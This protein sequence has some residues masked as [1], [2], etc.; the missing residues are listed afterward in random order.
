MS[1]VSTIELEI[2]DLEA[3]KKACVSLGFEFRENQKEYAWYGRHMGDYPIP[4]GMTKEDLGKC[5]HAI[6]VPGAKYEVGVISGQKPGTHQLIW[7]FWGSGGLV[8]KIGKRAEV[9]KRAYA[10]HRVR[11]AVSRQRGARVVSRNEKDDRIVIKVS[12]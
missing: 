4:E 12:I 11:R 3:L 1:H 8:P 2:N 7:D 10:E 9:L 5:Q 6:R